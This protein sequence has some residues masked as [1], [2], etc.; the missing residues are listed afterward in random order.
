[1]LREQLEKLR[2]EY[3]DKHVVVKDDRPELA[4]FRGAIGQVKTVNMNGKALVQF[5]VRADRGWYDI[6]L[7]H[8]KVV[9]PPPPKPAEKK[10]P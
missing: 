4:R 1:M 6:A 9:D 3:T 8:L 5:D 10:K 2:Q 7:D